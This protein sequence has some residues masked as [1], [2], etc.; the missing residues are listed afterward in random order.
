LRRLVG[1][2]EFN[3]A[4]IGQIRD[5]QSR[6]PCDGVLEIECGGELTADF[7]EQRQAPLDLQ[8]IVAGVPLRVV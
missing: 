2:P 3:S 6:H 4:P 1:R 5:D 8:R 7:D